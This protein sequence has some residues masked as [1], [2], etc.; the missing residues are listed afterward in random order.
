MGR[1]VQGLELRFARHLL[2][3]TFFLR[4]GVMDLGFRFRVGLG[5][6]VEGSKDS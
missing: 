4:L 5:L 3:C 2:F 1:G 6:R